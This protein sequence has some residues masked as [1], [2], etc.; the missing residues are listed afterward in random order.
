MG[1]G[2]AD[3]TVALNSFLSQDRAVFLPEG[4]YRHGAVTVAEG[5]DVLLHPNAVFLSTNPFQGVTVG[6]RA[7]FIGGILDGNA[8]ALESAF[9]AGW[10][11][12]LSVW[13]N[14]FGLI[15]SGEGAEVRTTLRNHINRPCWISGDDCR[16]DI[17][18]LNHGAAG[19]V[20]YQW[21]DLTDMVAR[22]ANSGARRMHGTIR[23]IRANNQ[24]RA[25]VFQHAID[26]H[27]TLGGKIYGYIEDMD[28]APASGT[29]E[30]WTSGHTAQECEDT[31]FIWTF[32]NGLSDTMTHLA[33][34]IPGSRNVTVDLLT[35]N[36]AG[37]AFEA[38]GCDGVYLR[39]ASLQT[40]G[41]HT[42]AV[43]KGDGSSVGIL[44]NGGCSRWPRSSRSMFPSRR[45]RLGDV[46][47]QG[48]T[49]G[50]LVNAQDVTL[51][52]VFSEANIESGLRFDDTQVITHIAGALP[53][54]V[55]RIHV[56]AGCRFER[57][58]AEGLQI[59][60]SGEAQIDPGVIFKNNGQDVAE[61]SRHGCSVANS[62][63]ATVHGVDASDNQDWTEVGYASFEPQASVNRSGNIGREG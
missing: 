38:N 14:G 57:N 4:T 44:M 59:N 39:R 34:S 5:C 37:Q 27:A 25:N 50:G 61:A 10:T 7:K 22:P 62:R 46:H 11:A 21:Y 45:M 43:P 49:Q 18:M 15:V 36:M 32:E 40:N 63:H 8:D 16:F 12:A 19:I 48:F 30:S 35:R 56:M 2:V 28:G 26:Y 3:D 58:G 20:G 53:L 55:E 42:T 60:A 33:A 41:R 54:R 24:G 52:A 9:E 51:E 31:E 6:P 23:S 29:S 17:T 1:G 13:S 47:I